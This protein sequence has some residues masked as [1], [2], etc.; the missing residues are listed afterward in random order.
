MNIIC[1]SIRPDLSTG[2][3]SQFIL[4]RVITTEVL[5]SCLW[6]ASLTNLEGQV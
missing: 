4:K 6:F 2:I 3:K 5:D 1:L